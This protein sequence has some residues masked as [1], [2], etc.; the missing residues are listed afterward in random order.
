MPKIIPQ[1]RSTTPMAGE[2]LLTL[3]NKRV[4]EHGAQMRF[5][6]NE[7]EAA[8]GIHKCVAGRC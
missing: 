5:V 4:V 3:V 7:I 1:N 6:C 8:E 2:V